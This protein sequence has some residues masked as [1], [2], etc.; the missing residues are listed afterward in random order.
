MSH[1]DLLKVA[2]SIADISKAVKGVRKAGKMFKRHLDFAPSSK[3]FMG[4]KFTTT[5]GQGM[6]PS[7]L[8]TSHANSSALTK[9]K[10]DP[11]NL[12]QGIYVK[13]S[14]GRVLANLS[15][16]MH[17]AKKP[18]LVDS[19]K[20]KLKPG[21]TKVHGIRWKAMSKEDKHMA[22]NIAMK[23]EMDEHNAYKQIKK[24]RAADGKKTPFNASLIGTS[25]LAPS[26]LFRESN[27]VAKAGHGTGGKEVY[28]KAKAL[29][30]NLR[31]SSG[32]ASFMKQYVKDIRAK[33]S[34][35]VVFPNKKS[36]YDKSEYEYGKTRLSR[37]AIKHLDRI[38]INHGHVHIYE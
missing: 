22:N 27:N 11:T 36:T 14:P 12:K 20:E 5:K 35:N 4:G 7:A 2:Y 19:I 9:S 1:S 37:H 29:Y 25:H 30:T 33:D 17:N 34:K 23:H 6:G 38:A 31:N 18:G 26:V 21:S 13:S 32:E 8:V 15:E 3:I 10:M 28:H 24:I 16:R